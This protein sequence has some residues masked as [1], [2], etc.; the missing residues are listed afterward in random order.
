MSCGCG[1]KSEKQLPV[2]VIGGGPVGLAAAAHLITRGESVVVLEAGS[3][4]GANILN[5][6]H[7]RLFSPWQYN[8]DKAA[9]QLLLAHGWTAPEDEKL[10]T[11]KELVEEY[12]QPL[13]ELP[14]L[15]PSI[16][17][18]AKVVG[19][20]RKGLDKVITKNRDSRPFV[21]YVEQAGDIVT[22]EAKAVLDA[23]GSWSNPN[24]T[25]SSGIWTSAEKSLSNHIAY[26]IPDVLHA[27]RDRYAGKSVVVVGG[28][29]SAIN[30]LLDL[31]ELKAQDPKTKIVWILRKPKVEDAYGG[32]EKDG[33]PARGQLGIRLR[34]LIESNTVT[35]L[36]PFHIEKLE[37]QGGSIT[38]T[39]SH[40]DELTTVTGV[41]EII[42]ATGGR[43][44]L[45]FLREV[46]LEFD[47]ALEST[48]EL[49]PL[50]D[51]NVHSCGTV[52]PHGEKELRQP[53]SG[54]YILGAKSYGR[55]PTFLLATGYEQAR[56]VVAGLVGDWKAAQDVQLELPETGVCKVSFNNL[57][58][59]SSCCA[60]TTTSCCG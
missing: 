18:N 12:L 37:D 33:L 20:G 43:P 21:L 15:K 53:E 2:V 3:T 16:Q 44:D 31:A 26:G 4:V 35:V 22:Y 59:S 24:P 25:L 49:A 6:G 34:H 58:D 54:F 7:V 23:T 32:E 28:G 42:C 48:K 9:K 50:I 52:R 10:P 40:K 47:P 27:Q 45:S 8:V 14:E 51:P 38:L 41:D 19:V 30:G 56:S 39:G 55:A 5:W 17:L 13:A 36:T 46:R 60:P 57:S 29:H 11:G 1:A